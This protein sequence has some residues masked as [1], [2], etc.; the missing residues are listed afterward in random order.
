MRPKFF[1]FKIPRNSLLV[2]R[3]LNLIILG[4]IPEATLAKLGSI[5]SANSN[6]GLTTSDLLDLIDWINKVVDDRLRDDFQ[7]Y[8]WESQRRQF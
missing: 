3:L 7:R 1:F 5:A 4:I 6:K 2:V 8:G